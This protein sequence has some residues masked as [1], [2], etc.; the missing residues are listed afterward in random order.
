MDAR[1]V[2]LFRAAADISFRLG[3]HATVFLNAATMAQDAGI[4]HESSV[5]ISSVK[6][7]RA[8]VV[9]P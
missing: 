4:G 1:N 7:P 6:K 3:N 5:A 2:D 9:G 8:Q